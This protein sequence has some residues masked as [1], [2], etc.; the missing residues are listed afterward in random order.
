MSPLQILT[1]HLGQHD[2]KTALDAIKAGGWMVVR[3]DAIK[4]AQAHAVDGL[5]AANDSRRKAA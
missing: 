2:A 4:L 5:R 3:Q 1:E